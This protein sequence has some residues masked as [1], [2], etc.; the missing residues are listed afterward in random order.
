MRFV[1]DAVEIA[2]RAMHNENADLIGPFSGLIRFLAE[3]PAA[4]C[5]LRGKN[6]PTVGSADY[7]RC[8]AK[9]FASS[10]LP[11]RPNPPATVPDEM[12]SIILVSY[13]G[14]P[15]EDAERVKQE[16]LLSMG[17][18]NI[19]GDLLE[20]YLASTLEPRGWIWCSGSTVKAVDFIKPPT[21]VGQPWRLLQVKNRDNSENSSSSAIRSG[22]NIEKWHRSFS[23]RAG[24]N[25]PEFPDPTFRQ[26][27][28]EQ[29]FTE[30]VRKYLTSLGEP[31]RR[32]VIDVSTPV[33]SAILRRD[34]VR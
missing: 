29:G 1:N 26:H 17:A 32:F 28:S 33:Q 14:I 19:V 20:R 24:S 25:W 12:V 13:F 22:T 2:Q 34:S 15:Q 9:A 7:I 18:E 16:H 5:P 11:K 31:D 3:N 23:R 21:V 6:R 8:Q 4:A 10:R 30:F 27:L